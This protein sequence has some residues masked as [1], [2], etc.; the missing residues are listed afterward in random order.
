MSLLSSIPDEIKNALR[1]FNDRLQ[2]I[3]NNDNNNNSLLNKMLKTK[4]TNKFLY[5]LLT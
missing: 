4:E 3:V 1:S 5:K 2:R